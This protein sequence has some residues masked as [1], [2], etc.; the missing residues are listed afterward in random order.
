MR[1]ADWMQLPCSLQGF[2]RQQIDIVQD[3]LCIAT[4]LESIALLPIHRN[5]DWPMVSGLHEPLYN[6]IMKFIQDALR[7]KASQ[8]INCL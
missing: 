7:R 5:P 2:E 8:L 3:F 6:G 4:C 1:I